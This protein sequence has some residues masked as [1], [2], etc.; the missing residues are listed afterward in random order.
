VIGIIGDRQI[1]ISVI[2]TKNLIGASLLFHDFKPTF[3]DQIE[4]SAKT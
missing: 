3:H 1:L 2:G 4:I